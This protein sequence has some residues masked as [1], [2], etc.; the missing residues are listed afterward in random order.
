M[1][2]CEKLVHGHRYGRVVVNKVTGEKTTVE[3]STHHPYRCDRPAFRLEVKGDS[4]T[5]FATLCKIHMA[6]AER[7]GFKVKVISD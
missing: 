1:A 5:A 2:K 4:F 6:A 3:E 7:E